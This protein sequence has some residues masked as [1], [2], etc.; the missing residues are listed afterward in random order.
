MGNSDEGIHSGG[1][2]VGVHSVIY[3]GGGGA[4]SRV[5]GTVHYTEGNQENW[6]T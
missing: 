5:V 4:P 6:A 2:G 1:V 3:M